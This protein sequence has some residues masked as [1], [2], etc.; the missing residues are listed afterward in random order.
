MEAHIFFF[1][2]QNGR[3]EKNLYLHFSQVIFIFS[4]VSNHFEGT[5]R[6]IYLFLNQFGPWILFNEHLKKTISN[7]KKNGRMS[8][9]QVRVRKG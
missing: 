6:N 2:L 3:T 4:C 7:I 9:G 5:E 1:C 8:G